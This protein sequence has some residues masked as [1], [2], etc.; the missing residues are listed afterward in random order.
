MPKYRSKPERTFPLRMLCAKRNVMLPQN[1]HH[2]I[3]RILKSNI[4]TC[5]EIIFIIIYPPFYHCGKSELNLILFNTQCYF[6]DFDES[7]HDWENVNTTEFINETAH[8]LHDFVDRYFIQLSN[9]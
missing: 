9:L 3:E 1:R 7:E 6:T 5:L 2:G 8:Q 4:N